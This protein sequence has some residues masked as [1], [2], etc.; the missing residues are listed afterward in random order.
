LIDIIKKADKKIPPAL[1]Q[2][3]GIRIPPGQAQ[4]PQ[5]SEIS[6]RLRREIAT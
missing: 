3:T 5:R 6:P 2:M 1:A 4:L